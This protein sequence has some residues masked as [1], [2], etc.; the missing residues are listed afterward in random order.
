MYGIILIIHNLHAKIVYG[1]R[2]QRSGSQRDQMHF[3]GGSIP[4]DD[5]TSK[6]V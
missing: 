1:S 4:I 2:G 3:F 6:T 5:S